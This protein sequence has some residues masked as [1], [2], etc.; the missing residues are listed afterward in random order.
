MKGVPRPGG[1]LVFDQVQSDAAMKNPPKFDPVLNN[2]D[3]SRL[4]VLEY[5]QNLMEVNIF[6]FI[7]AE[8]K[9]GFYASSV[10]V[11]IRLKDDWGRLLSEVGCSN[12]D[13]FG[14]FKFSEYDKKS[15]QRLIA[16]AQK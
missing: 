13:Y 3:F 1:I 12:V 8:E 15:S 14:D 6:D 16:V 11:A 2:R 9:F 10:N 4:F 7:H 5:S